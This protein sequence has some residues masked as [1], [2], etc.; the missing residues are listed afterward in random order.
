MYV[1][2]PCDLN[3]VSHGTCSY[4]YMYIKA[5]SNGAML[6]LHLWHY[7]YKVVIK[8]KHKVRVL[9]VHYVHFDVK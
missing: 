7:F 2:K 9:K 5:V 1:I 6:Q 3:Q 4:I 8:I